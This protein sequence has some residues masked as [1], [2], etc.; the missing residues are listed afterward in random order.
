MKNPFDRDFFGF[1]AGFA[2][3]I[4]AGLFVIFAASF[5]ENNQSLP[6]QV[7]ER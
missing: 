2:L 3:M 1:L 7:I 5:Y 4:C 6:A